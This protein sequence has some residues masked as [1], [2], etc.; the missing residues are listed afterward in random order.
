MP[1]PLASPTAPDSEAADLCT[2]DHTSATTSEVDLLANALADAESQSPETL[3]SSPN[4]TEPHEEATAVVSRK[5]PIESLVTGLSFLLVLTV[6]QRF[7]GL[8]RSVLFCRWM[9]D[10]ELGQWSLAFSFLMIAAPLSVLGL[11]G[12]FGRYVERYRQAGLLPIFL[13]RVGLVCLFSSGLFITTLAIA[14]Q[15]FTELIFRS[16][17]ASFLPVLIVTLALVVLSNAL[18]E[19]MN[20]L[21]QIRI[22]SLMRFGASISF[23]AVSFALLA[24]GLNGPSAAIIGF[25][26]GALL[27]IL[28]ASYSLW[29][30]RESLSSINSASKECDAESVGWSMW[31]TLIS[32]AVWLWLLDLLTNLVTISDRY[33]LLH[34]ASGSAEEAQ[35]LVGQYHSSLVIPSIFQAVALMVAGAALPYLSKDWEAGRRAHVSRTLNVMLKGMLITM[36]IGA[37]I[38]QI[39][40]PL[41]FDLLLQGRYA[42]GGSVLPWAFACFIWLGVAFMA[43]QYLMCAEKGKWASLTLAIT[44]GVNIGLNA[45]LVP[46]FGLQGVVWAT[47]AANLSLVVMTLYL[48]K[49]WGMNLDHRIW[50]LSAFPILLPISSWL[51]LLFAGCVC[52]IRPLRTSL[53]DEPEL[54]QMN[55]QL[56][57]VATRLKLDRFLS[58]N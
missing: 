5:L 11:P 12:C 52:L 49:R 22:A 40:S 38:C 54:S 15:P 20:G 7:I 2:T 57:K 41:L 31:K 19:L 37:A 6:V 50:Y 27:A 43:S 53:F 24:I 10:S 13:R 9:S 3:T 51:P 32:F 55:A 58:A 18:M 23:A 36:T 56:Q 47:A 29:C 8:A 21:R 30:Y 26:S 1:N 45:I 33:M 46:R 39:A 44:V 4:S 14:R 25:G 28:I 17:S 34:F 35:G 16:Q 42:V 48:I